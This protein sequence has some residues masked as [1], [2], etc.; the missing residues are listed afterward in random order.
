[1][2]FA[3]AVALLGLTFSIISIRLMLM[4]ENAQIV[5]VGAIG[6]RRQLLKQND[7]IVAVAIGARKFLAI[8][9][10]IV[11]FGKASSIIFATQDM[12]PEK[13]VEGATLAMMNT[14]LLSN[15]LGKVVTKHGRDAAEKIMAVRLVK[16]RA[17]GPGFE[18]GSKE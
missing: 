6:K 1:M 7:K 5:M 18:P 4:A 17:P 14:V 15:K 3:A 11:F 8:K 9:I 13:I 16:R 10:G 2:G 12:Y